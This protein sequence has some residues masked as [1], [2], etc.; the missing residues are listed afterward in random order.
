MKK[1][2]F[3]LFLLCGFTPI[4]QGQNNKQV[5]SVVE[6]ITDKHTIHVK[7]PST[8][9]TEHSYSKQDTNLAITSPDKLLTVLL[10]LRNGIPTYSV[11]Y[12]GK[13]ML[14]ESP[15]GLISTIGDFSQSMTLVSKKD[16]S[17]DKTYTQSKIK[18]SSV[19][20]QANE[21][22]CT[23]V[24]SQK[25]QI[26]IVFRVSN[27][28]IAFRYVLPLTGET[29][30]CIIKKETTGFNFPAFTTTFLTPQATPM[31][32]WKQTK[33]SY[34]EEY[35]V[36]SPLGTPSKYGLGF[37]F[38]GLFRI[39]N[40]GWVLVS[41]T[42]VGSSYCG[43][44]LSEG[45]KDGLF[46]IAFPE[47]G[48]NNGI[49]N[50]E[51]GV[52]LPGETPWRTITIGENLKPIVETTIPFDVV[53]PLYKSSMDYKYGR[54]TW[55]WIMW[56]DNS[57]NYQDQV[58]YID[59]AAKLGYEYV[60]ID[61][62][63]DKQIGYERMSDLLK[64][65][66]SKG[67][68]IFLWYNSNGFWND[69]PQGPKQRMNTSVSRKKE[70]Q[71][72]KSLGVKGLKVDF[73]GGDKQETIKLYEDILSDANDYGLMVIFH[74][75]TL[76]RGWERMYPNYVSS[77]AVLA[78]ENLIFNQHFDDNE[79]FNACLHPFIRNTVGSMDFGGTL[80]NKRLNRTNTG[81]TTRR[82]TDIFQLAT[83]VLFQSPIQNFALAP[84]NLTDV[85][86][87]EIDFMK[88]VP[89]SWDET[90]YI[91]GYPGKYCVLARRH[92]TKWYVV[93][94]NAG[95]EAL[96]LKLNLPMLKNSEV[97]YYTDKKDGKS[98]LEKAQ[99]KQAGTVSVEI[100]PQGGIILTN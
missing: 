60:L 93:G 14:E 70:M 28:D 74:G 95:K 21:L 82:T 17:I 92:G 39:G 63:W 2:A 19:H 77:E 96:K 54:A 89:T 5:Y 52:A 62:L 73:F 25:Q 26:Q 23:Y 47:K 58:T 86:G 27:N 66:Q 91:D 81:G 44:R 3:A 46:T 67:V 48:E 11:N 29:A 68:D 53:E 80:L 20:Y 4:L 84:N 37:T 51:P 8:N 38:P 6:K 83:A 31:I 59:F 36:D 88:Q 50:S 75:C 79:A 12:K 45:T 18:K 49:G 16:S 94:I 22:T 33:P 13:L 9:I 43:S 1:I 65:A 87:F 55:S 10:G 7:V 72:L 90:L 42:G 56:Q 40:Q 98:S 41:E 69:A 15:L 35:T 76:P 61:A 34:E 99:I 97:A 71:W 100:Q 57:A 85:P 24:N 32:G 30:R 64:Y 78:S